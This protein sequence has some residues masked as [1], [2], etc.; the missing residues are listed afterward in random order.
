MKEMKGKRD[1]SRFSKQVDKKPKEQ[2]E[3]GGE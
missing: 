1:G 2:K 3:V